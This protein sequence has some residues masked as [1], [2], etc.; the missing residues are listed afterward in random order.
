MN[1]EQNK[2]KKQSK[3]EFN[4]EKKDKKLENL[5]KILLLWKMSMGERTTESFLEAPIRPN[6]HRM[7]TMMVLC[8]SIENNHEKEEEKKFSLKNFS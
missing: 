7:K 3:K 1:W 4:E 6:N 5:W 2:K 8:I